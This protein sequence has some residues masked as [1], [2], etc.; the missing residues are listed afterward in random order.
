[1]T[2]ILVITLSLFLYSLSSWADLRPL[3]LPQEKHAIK[4]L[5]QFYSTT[6]S[7]KVPTGSFSMEGSFD[8]KDRILSLTGTEWIKRPEN[9]EMVSLKGT[10]NSESTS[11]TGRVLFEGCKEFVLKRTSRVAGSPIA[12]KWEGSYICAQG[13]TGL[14]LTVK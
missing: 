3:K 4:A 6:Y 12:G 14:T 11:F 9:Y 7:P 10:I 1:M 13:V 8:E 2:K 5:F